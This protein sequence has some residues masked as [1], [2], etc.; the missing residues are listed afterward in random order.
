ML[1]LKFQ[2]TLLVLIV[3]IS[4]CG[5]KFSLQKRHY[6]HGYNLSFAKQQK[7]R[8]KSLLAEKSEMA[9]E[10]LS[11]GSEQTEIVV[12]GFD[13]NP[14][15]QVALHGK[16]IEQIIKNNLFKNIS[17]SNLTTKKSD[18]SRRYA[19]FTIKNKTE[20]LN[21]RKSSSAPTNF[22]EALGNIYAGY[23]V[24]SVLI[25]VGYLIWLLFETLPL[26]EAIQILAIAI[27]VVLIFYAI[28]SVFTGR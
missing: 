22:F 11:N 9:T 23:I 18:E 3:F 12:G 20:F 15:G 2:I 14:N 17:L 10:S 8:N 26:I 1:K 6:R 28:G 27:G 7:K 5:T 24:V 25:T 4:G 21:S 19:P 16:K 13:N